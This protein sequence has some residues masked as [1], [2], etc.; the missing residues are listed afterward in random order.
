MTNTQQKPSFNLSELTT[1]AV[2]TVQE[3]TRI[4][5]KGYSG[6]I[7]RQLEEHDTWT[8]GWF[9]EGV[10][11][12]LYLHDLRH[13][14]NFEHLFQFLSN[15]PER[16]FTIAAYIGVGLAI[17]HSGTF[18]SEVYEKLD[19]EDRSWVFDGLGFYKILYAQNP[20]FTNVE[21]PNYVDLEE[22]RQ[23]AF[24]SGVG[25]GLWFSVGGYEIEKLVKAAGSFPTRHQE[26]IWCGLGFASTYAGGT[27]QILLNLKEKAGVNLEFL[28]VGSAIA[29]LEQGKVQVAHRE[30]AAQVFFGKSIFEIVDIVFPMGV[31]RDHNTKI[32]NA[33][34]KTWIEETLAVLK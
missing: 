22:E 33:T 12:G 18:S 13:E 24:Y 16:G 28:R 5:L 34:S 4:G 3:G 8:E 7:R 29:I 27:E 30:S 23:S 25:R 17:G 15:F 31:S 1:V 26:W 6:A 19:E 14:N 32:T 21:I 11:Q 9:A 2:N 10:G 20:T